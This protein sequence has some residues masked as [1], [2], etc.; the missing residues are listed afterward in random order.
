MIARL[1]LFVPIFLVC[2]SIG[3]V[4]TRTDAQSAQHV[5]DCTNA[6]QAETRAMERDEESAQLVYWARW[7]L[8][9][10]R[11][12]FRGPEDEASVLSDLERGLI[13]QHNFEDA[14]PIAQRCI[15]IK[16]DAAYCFVDLGEAFLGLG[17][18][19]DAR[20]A[21]EQAV[22]I[23]GYDNVNAAAIKVAHQRLQFLQGM[24]SPASPSG[25]GEAAPSTTAATKFGS[26]FFVTS[27]GHILTNNH[28]V[29]GCKSLV[30]RDG[31]ALSIVSQN[32]NADLA[33]LKSAIKP[34]AVASFGKSPRVGD[35][36]MT[37]GFP[38]P[39][40]L[41]SEGNSTTGIISALSGLGGDINLFQITAPIQ[42]GNSGGPLVDQHGRVVGVIVAKLDA[43]EVAKD[44]GD[45]PQNVN[46]AIRDSVA[47]AFLDSLGINYRTS[48]S[49]VTLGWPAVARAEKKM[50][51]AIVCTE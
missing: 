39:G 50:S 32:R 30:T 35:A 15:T 44:T 23:G 27:E 10:C 33:V 11:D 8:S 5:N 7:N 4:A 48:A 31:E 20:K 49:N 21:Y 14:I 19:G 29:V 38:L 45:V 16:P 46:F 12:L 17:R 28:V 36:V 2:L 3:L 9:N 24:E 6:L 34:S 47:T 18:I 1:R 51:V 40:L 22:S 42:P 25:A 43:L 37:F 13:E 41:A 26:G